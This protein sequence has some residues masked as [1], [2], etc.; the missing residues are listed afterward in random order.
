MNGEERKE[1]LI[2]DEKT[3]EVDYKALHPRMIYHLEKID[4]TDDPYLA[5]CATAAIRKPIKKLFQMMINANTRRKAVYAFEEYLAE[6]P[7]IADLLYNDGLNGWELANMI[8]NAHKRIK[9]YFNTGIGV[10]LQF[11]DSQIAESILKHFTK[12]K[13]VCL[14]IHDSFIVP[15]KYQDELI[16][17]MKREYRKRMGFEGLVKVG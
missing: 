15:L 13:I 10:K 14:C 9:D 4:Y 2:N 12:Q 1:I 8:L 17:I 6:E 11:I 16:E 7:A 3:I 5:V